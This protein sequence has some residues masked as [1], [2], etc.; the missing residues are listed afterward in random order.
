M[1]ESM[2]RNMFQTPGRSYLLNHFSKHAGHGVNDLPDRQT[3]SVNQS[4]S[5]EVLGVV[6]EMPALLQKAQP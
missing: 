3:H 5:L 1:S 4:V 2:S 6:M